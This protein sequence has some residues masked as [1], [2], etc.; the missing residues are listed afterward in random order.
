MPPAVVERLPRGGRFVPQAAAVVVRESRVP[1]SVRRRADR[2][3]AGFRLFVHVGDDHASGSALHLSFR[4]AHP[5][6]RAVHLL[7]V[8]GESHRVQ[9]D[10]NAVC[11][12]CGEVQC[13][14]LHSVGVKGVFFQRQ[15]PALLGPRVESNGTRLSPGQGRQA[16]EKGREN[17]LF[18][19]RTVWVCSSESD[20]I[21]WLP[22]FIRAPGFCFRP[23]R[24]GTAVLTGS[25]S[26][27]RHRNLTGTTA[28]G[29]IN[30]WQS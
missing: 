2:E 12:R 4:N 8:R 13:L 25:G 21:R 9:L 5:Y 16:A 22:V 14:V 24:R 17:V 11:R 28:R 29:R 6:G 1:R 26:G 30:Q 20:G 3:S 23:A 27:R 7:A 10:G 15:N 18:H 19:D